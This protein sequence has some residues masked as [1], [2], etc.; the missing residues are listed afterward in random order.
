M[1]WLTVKKTVKLN[2]KKHPVFAFT[3][4]KCYICAQAVC[5]LCTKLSTKARE[6]TGIQSFGNLCSCLWT[7]GGLIPAYISSP[8]YLKRPLNIYSCPAFAWCIFI[9]M[10]MFCPDSWHDRET[11]TAH[12]DLYAHPTYEYLWEFNRPKETYFIIV[13]T[14]LGHICTKPCQAVYFCSLLCS[15]L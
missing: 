2:F 9:N 14:D 4:I 7:S 13:Q 6:S 1:H 15:T 12:V 10:C 3:G 5:I 11:E 8:W